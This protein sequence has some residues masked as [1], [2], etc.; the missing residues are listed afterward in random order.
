MNENIFIVRLTYCQVLVKYI[1][2]WCYTT[3]LPELKFFFSLSLP[4]CLSAVPM[5]LSFLLL[6]C[7]PQRLLFFS[8][9]NS[10]VQTFFTLWPT[11]DLYS[12]TRFLLSKSSVPTVGAPYPTVFCLSCLYVCMWAGL[13]L[14][15]GTPLPSLCWLLCFPTLP[16][17]THTERHSHTCLLM[18]HGRAAAYFSTL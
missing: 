4:H 15:Y 10:L 7:S 3:I 11:F 12:Y 18:P 1:R 16:L 2:F 8:P 6:M 14:L 17:Q 13:E 5:A 9:S